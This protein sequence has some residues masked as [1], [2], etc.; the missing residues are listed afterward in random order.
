G[1]AEFVVGFGVN[2][3]VAG[4]FAMRLAVVV[5]APEI[6]AAGHRRERS[7]EGKDFEAVA[8]KIEVANDFRPQQRDYVRT[9][10]ELESRHDFFGTGRA[11]EDV[12]ALEHEDFFPGALQVGGV[13]QTVVS[14]ADDDYV[15]RN[16]H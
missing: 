10:G 16:S 1:F 12:T 3:G 5:H 15:V 2:A 4:D 11:P 9:D 7:V 14:A 8:G 13:D 6:V